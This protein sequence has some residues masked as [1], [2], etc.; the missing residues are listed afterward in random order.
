MRYHAL[1]PLMA[2]VVN[3][4]LSVPVLRQGL[5]TPML[6]VF[7]LM[8][9][10]IASWNLDIFALY[11]FT[12]PEAAEWWSRVFRT[13]ICFA[14]VF[15]FHASLV[16]A[17][18]CRG[19][20][21][22]LLVAGY[23]AGVFLAIANLHGD[24]VRG[25]TPHTWGWY[26]QATPLYS[27]MTGML[28]LYLPIILE[29]TW[30]A[31]R[32]PSSPRQRVQAKFWFFAAGVQVPFSLT[33]LL[34]IYGVNFYP[35]GNI[36]NVFFVAILAYAIVRHRL[37]DVDYVVRKFVSFAV[38]SAVILVPGAIM[39]FGL[40][41]ALGS[42]EPMVLTCAAIAL[43]LIAVVLIPTLQQ[44]LETR[45]HRAL[46]PQLYDYRLRLRQLST[47]LVHILDQTELVRRLGESLTDILDLEQCHVFV[48]DEVSRRLALCHPSAGAAEESLPTEVVQSLEG[49]TA[50]MLAAELET[51][52]PAAASF[53][54]ARSWEV[55]VPLR[56]NDRLTGVVSLGR[57]R[58]FRIFSGED[59]QLLA[60]VAA[61]ASVALENATLSRQ[62]RHSEAVLERANRLSSLGLLAAGIAHEIRNPLV[63]VK[64]F[65]DLLPQRLEDREFLT[66]FRDLSLGEL[67]RVTDL[68]TDLLA[69][70]K[71]KTA[72]RRAVEVAPT[73]EPVVR[74]MEST[75]RKR[76]IEVVVAFDANL[77]AVWA[78]P[79]QLKQI[80]LNLLLNA[81]ESSTAGGRVALDVRPGLVDGV[82][83]EVRDDGPGIPPEQRETIFH[84]FFTT[85]ESG[86]GLGLTLVHQMV[87]EHGGEITVESDVGRGS[88]FRVLLPGAR[89]PLAA[90]GS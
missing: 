71:S 67:R 81:I 6:R 31:Y 55:A 66:N 5:R 19:R 90:T 76:Q 25:L 65:L 13:G 46:F 63:A 85:K 32:H 72:E 69:L 23:V 59:L 80:M 52:S 16:L 30:R 27:V 89:L 61:G 57:N 70:G 17:E 20:W 43:A 88:V 62:L 87:V 50:P 26:I 28:L 51:E 47:A 14:P 79:D 11:Y 37:M 40:A 82:V 33:N 29:R 44:A 45:V 58:D 2:A 21:L 42:E 78:D 60:S 54:R 53:F 74:L 12:D 15:A 39:L 68:I 24:L 10:A 1:V 41:R 48:R 8:T 84:P 38:A 49:I 35:L 34:P 77:P 3:L 22:V 7:T 9:L 73:L 83:F 18:S 36:G 86:T 64:T 56:I 4:V 75:A